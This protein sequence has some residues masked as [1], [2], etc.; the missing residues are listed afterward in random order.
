MFGSNL[1]SQTHMV[2]PD[3]QEFKTIKPTNLFAENQKYFSEVRLMT[4]TNN[5]FGK[6][7]G[8]SLK[9]IKP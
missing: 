3:V 5:M 8:P 1:K 4:E 7:K 2:L 6:N 9:Q